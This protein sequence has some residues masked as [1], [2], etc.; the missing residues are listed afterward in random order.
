MGD[1]EQHE[2]D[3]DEHPHRSG[4]GAPE[5][6]SQALLEFVVPAEVEQHAGEIA[7][8][9]AGADQL[10]IEGR[11]AILL[12]FEG[13]LK[14]RAA[15]HLGGEEVDGLGEPAAVHVLGDQPQAVLDGH[16]SASEMGELLVEGDEILGAQ[17]LGRDGASLW[18]GGFDAEHAD[19]Q[20]GEKPLRLLRAGGIDGAGDRLAVERLG[21][22]LERGDGW[23]GLGHD[24]AELTLKRGGFLP[25]R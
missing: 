16:A 13:L 17:R 7:A 12:R 8:G 20:G 24:R 5:R 9:D 2:H 22:V 11:E 21:L 23:G 10:G 3:A 1:E 25:R 15:L 18:R 4:G 19:P 6:S 14:R